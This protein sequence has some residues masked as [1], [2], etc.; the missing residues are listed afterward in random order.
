[1]YVCR[2]SETFGNRGLKEQCMEQVKKE[3]SYDEHKNLAWKASDRDSWLQSI[4]A[5][6]DTCPDGGI[7]L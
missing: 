1:M 3:S 7:L 6:A 2:E 5:N 4:N